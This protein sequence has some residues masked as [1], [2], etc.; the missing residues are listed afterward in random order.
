[1]PW[2]TTEQEAGWAKDLAWKP[3]RSEK[4][5]DP[6][7]NLTSITHSSIQATAYQPHKLHYLSCLLEP[8]L[9]WMYVSYL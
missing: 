5:L 8:V 1:M 7:E 6:V 3:C 2:V 4:F 9:S